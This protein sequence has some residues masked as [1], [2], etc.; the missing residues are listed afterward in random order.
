MNPAIRLVL[1]M[2]QIF[3]S[4]TMVTVTAGNSAGE[5]VILVNFQE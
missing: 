1:S 4:L 3:L 2:V 5:I